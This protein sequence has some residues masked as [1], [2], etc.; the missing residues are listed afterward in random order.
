MSAIYWTSYP[1]KNRKQFKQLMNDPEFKNEVEL[2]KDIYKTIEYN[3]NKRLKAM[4]QNE[5]K[6]I[7]TASQ[8][9]PVRIFS[10]KRI[11][12]VA[13]TVLFLI[14]I[15]WQFFTPKDF[16]PLAEYFVPE[17]NTL[18][19][20]VKSGDDPT[21]IER[22]FNLYDQKEYE[23]ALT[24]FEKI[25]S[26]TNNDDIAFYQ[27]NAYLA[28]KKPEK[29]IPILQK[30]IQ[31]NQSDYLAPAKWSL[32]L[33]YCSQKNYQAAKPLL[34]EIKDNRFLKSK[35]EKLLNE[36]VFQDIK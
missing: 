16:D 18:Y 3:E 26:E 36:A 23:K 15:Y 25:L 7:K 28:T 14:F 34:E 8:K 5:E 21:E 29:A 13:A 11:A 24:G 12:A 17:T 2:K 30:I 27:A 4:L 10:I 22:T 6:A 33:A 20:T 9:A 32:A 1:L 31:N 35:V 19:P